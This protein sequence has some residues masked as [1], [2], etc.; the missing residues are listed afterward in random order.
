MGVLPGFKGILCDDHWAPDYKLDCTHALC[1]AHHLRKLTRAWEQD[2]QQWAHD[3]KDLLEKIY[4]RVIDAGG[5]LNAQQAVIYRAR[6]RKLIQKGE[7]EC[8]EPSRPNKKGKRGG[9]KNQSLAICW[10]D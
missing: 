9:S 10:S 8:L 5:V 3:M 1:N 7:I 2:D 6:Y 4:T